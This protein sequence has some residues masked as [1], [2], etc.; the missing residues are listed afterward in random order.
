MSATWGP[1][2][3]AE[4]VGG[5]KKNHGKDDLPHDSNGKNV[6][7]KWRGSKTDRHWL[8]VVE[9]MKSLLNRVDNG[10]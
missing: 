1:C 6:P 5:L 2:G 10:R 9:R 3:V 4:N 8:M 7:I